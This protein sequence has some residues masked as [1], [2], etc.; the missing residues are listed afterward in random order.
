MA[1]LEIDGQDTDFTRYVNGVEVLFKK[2]QSQEYFNGEIRVGILDDSQQPDSLY[3]TFDF[4]GQMPVTITL[5][6]DEA[7]ALI[8]M[9]SHCL[10]LKNLN[11]M[12]KNMED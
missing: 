9:L 12:Q 2:I 1:I 3:F 5:R 11:D 8:S 4:E 10:M 6:P 7:N